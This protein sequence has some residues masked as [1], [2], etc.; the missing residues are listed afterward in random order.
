M[1]FF[2]CY[3]KADKGWADWISWRLEEANYQIFYPE[4]DIH[5][6]NNEV[7]EIHRALAG[8]QEEAVRRVILV[9]SPNFSGQSTQE[10]VWTSLHQA[11]PEGTK[12]LL[13][14]VI[15][16]PAQAFF[17]IFNSYKSIDLSQIDD[18]NTA[19]KCLL[20][21]ISGK[22]QKP[23]LKPSFPNA[24]QKDNQSKPGYPGQLA[25]TSIQ[26]L[27]AAMVIN[28]TQSVNKKC[29]P[30]YQLGLLD[31]RLQRDHFVTQVAQ[32][33]CL[34]DGQTKGFI[35]SGPYKEWP[36]ALK[37]KLAYG[38]TVD[39]IRDPKYSPELKSLKADKSLVNR[40]PAEVLWEM[41]AFAM[42]ANPEAA[43]EENIR[44]AL[45]KLTQCHI[46]IRKLSTE[47]AKNQPFLV[48]MLS[49]WSSLSLGCCACSHFLLLIRE[50]EHDEHTPSSWLRFIKRQLTWR[51][52]MA[53]FLKQHGLLESLLPPLVSPLKADIWDW[54]NDHIEDS[55]HDDIQ[56]ALQKS[57]LKSPSIPH[58]ELKKILLPILQKH[59]SN[60]S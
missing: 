33:R 6:G 9:I 13:I 10:I 47:E 28:P 53:V 49:A 50:T 37:F 43:D 54:L 19:V 55:L 52:K 14:P 40:Q 4:W 31:R 20:N 22:R 57:L 38:L 59:P 24:G 29:P 16:K 8:T 46:F 18:E 60:Q 56:A 35:A 23:L 3:N 12:G 51:E 1:D 2:I 48:G 15:V 11:D 32:K 42:G 45:E 27:L 7:I 21:G 34:K 25:V 58:G 36:E 39:L 30:D 5:A 41:L 17:S 44:T 26:P